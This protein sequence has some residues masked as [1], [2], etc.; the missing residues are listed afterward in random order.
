MGLEKF[1]PGERVVVDGRLGFY[2]FVQERSDG[3][4]DVRY[5]GGRHDTAKP[6][7]VP[8]GSVHKAPIMRANGHS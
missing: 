2:I 5:L 6:E 1:S 3:K 8:S 7:P 4:T